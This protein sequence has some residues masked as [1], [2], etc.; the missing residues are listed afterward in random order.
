MP[1]LG[2]DLAY[3]VEIVKD[4]LAELVDEVTGS[5]E[6]SSNAVIDM[7]EIDCEGAWVLWVKTGVIAAGHALWLIVV[8]S[9]GE[10]LE[11]YLEPKAGRRGG[12]RGQPDERRRRPVAGA[13]SRVFFRGGIPDLDQAIADMIPGRD[14]VAGRRVG[15]GEHIFWTG[16]NV[17]DQVLWYYLLVEATETF[18]TKWHSGMMQS[19]KCQSLQNGY[20]T[21]STPP[22]TSFLQERLWGATVDLIGLTESNLNV[23]NL[24]FVGYDSSLVHSSAMIIA[25]SFF[26]LENNNVTGNV[27]RE[28]RIWIVENQNAD[29]GMIYYDGTVTVSAGPN[30]VG[31]AQ[32]DGVAFAS[33]FSLVQFKVEILGGEG[34]G[35]MTLT[36]TNQIA[37][38]TRNLEID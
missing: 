21:F 2:T 31:S 17:V 1:P 4:G 20:A 34:G 6:N 14:L 30:S 8:P 11:N 12:R 37:V 9:M 18:T 19:G 29:A 25:S 15:P 35:D 24:G 38:S 28:I 10:I 3:I 27:S 32:L 36:M 7:W 33:K 13:G 5:I 22:R 23:S 26:V 16:L